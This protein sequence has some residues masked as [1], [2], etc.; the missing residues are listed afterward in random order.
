MIPPANASKAGRHNVELRLAR[1]RSPVADNS[2]DVVI[3]NCVINLSPDKQQVFRYLQGAEGWWTSGDNRY[4]I[5]RFSRAEKEQAG[6]LRCAAG[7]VQAG[8]RMDAQ[9]GGLYGYRDNAQRGEQRIHQRLVPGWG[10]RRVCQ[11]GP[12]HGGEKVVMRCEVQRMLLRLQ[13][14]SKCGGPGGTFCSR[15]N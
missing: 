2:V 8:D 9:G 11:V 12:H 10:L 3:S 5:T 1:S 14:L 13:Q 15:I 7:A 6:I 4:R